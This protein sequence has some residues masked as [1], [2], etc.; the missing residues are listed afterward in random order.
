[1]SGID[2]HLIHTCVV[3]RAVLQEDRYKNQ[4]RDFR[5][6]LAEVRCR[7]VI[8]DEQ[9]VN[10]ITAELVVR[11]VERLFVPAGTDIQAGDRIG[12]VTVENGTVLSQT[13]EVRG[14]LPRRGAYARHLSLALEQVS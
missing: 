6:H 12:P 14:A 2:G 5:V 1:M 9:V 7:L 13:W 11:T 10:S 8:R 3:Y 4:K